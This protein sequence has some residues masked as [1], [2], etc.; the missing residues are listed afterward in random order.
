MGN[1]AMGMKKGEGMGWGMV[2]IKDR[3]L[4]AAGDRRCCE[5]VSRGDWRS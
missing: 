4:G 3:I 5:L 1:G 2:V